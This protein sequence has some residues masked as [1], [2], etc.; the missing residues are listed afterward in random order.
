M[1]QD[2]DPILVQCPGCRNRYYLEQ[3]VDGHCPNDDCRHQHPDIMPYSKPGENILLT[4][5]LD[6]W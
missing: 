2:S 5:S 6:D 1:E 3:F 4:T